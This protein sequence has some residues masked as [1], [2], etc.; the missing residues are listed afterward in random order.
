MSDTDEEREILRYACKRERSPVLI[1]LLYSTGMGVGELVL[2]NCWD[3]HW[4]T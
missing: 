1:E 3:I 4:D 2:L